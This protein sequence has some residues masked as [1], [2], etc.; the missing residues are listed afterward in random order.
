[1]TEAMHQVLI[2]E[3]DA[4]LQSVLRTFF[5]ANGYRV[6]AATIALGGI[7]DARLYNPDVVIV[8]LGLPDR[9]GVEVIQGIRRWSAMPI[10]VLSARTAESQRL[11][12]FENGADDYVV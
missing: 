3:D 7:R 6:V 12:A 9:D 8:D 5:E 2:V 4:A 10:V 1:M 11:S